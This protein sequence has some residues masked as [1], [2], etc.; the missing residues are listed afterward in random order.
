[1][2]LRPS[3]LAPWQDE[4]A[5]WNSVRPS[6]TSAGDVGVGAL[7]SPGPAAPATCPARWGCSSA[8]RPARRASRWWDGWRSLPC[9]CRCR[10]V[11]AGCLGGEDHQCTGSHQDRQSP[12]Q[13]R[14]CTRPA[15]PPALRQRAHAGLRG[16]VTSEESAG[17]AAISAEASMRCVRCA[18][19]SILTIAALE[20][21]SSSD[22]HCHRR[23][24]ARRRP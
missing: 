6:L 5:S 10:S 11:A 3:R 16:T 13:P 22:H 21:R 1:M 19:A 8:A 9:S 12:P 23:D 2:S 18:S 24:R 17:A 20:R 7:G 4:Q 14:R 15:S